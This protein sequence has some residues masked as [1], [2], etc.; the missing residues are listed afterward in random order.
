MARKPDGGLAAR[1]LPP[2][3]YRALRHVFA[4]EIAGAMLVGGTALA[5]YYAGH[6]RSD[7]L[8]LFTADEMAH[9]AT[10]LA[11]RSLGDV[12]TTLTDERSSAHFYHTTCRLAGHDFTAQVV[13]DANLF[14]LGSG[15]AASD[16]VVVAT[17]QTLL[18]MKSATLVSR[19][20]EKDLYDLKWFFDEDEELD[21]PTLIALGEEIDGGMNAEAVLINLVG[22]EMQPSACGFSLT[23]TSEQVLEEVN[24]VRAGLISGVEAYLHEKAP[25]PIA[26]LIRRLE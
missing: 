16:G 1:V 9:K 14:D 2:P 23:Q 3:L 13:L 12:G 15:L 8:D 6:R 25:P 5:G 4:Q 24:R 18:K 7:D 26:Q 11:V 17:P 21:I 22:T 10:V 20:S 19:A